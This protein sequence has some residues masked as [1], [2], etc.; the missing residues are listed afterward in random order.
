MTGL[1]HFAELIRQRFELTCR[2]LGLARDWLQ[3][4]ASRFTPPPPPKNDGERQL[5]LF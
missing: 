1:G 2:R 5:S 4:D 3:L